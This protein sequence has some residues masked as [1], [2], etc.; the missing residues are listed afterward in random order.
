M[1]LDSQLPIA[2]S[3]KAR[4]GI[5][6]VLQYAEQLAMDNGLLKETD[7]YSILAEPQFREFFGKYTVQVGSTGN[8]GLSIGI[9][10]AKLGFRVMVHMSMD[11][12]QWKKDLLRE[13]GVTVVEYPDDYGKAVEEGRKRSQS[14]PMSYF[15]DDENSISLFLGYTVAGRRL[16]RQ[17]EQRGI[18]VDAEHP[19]FVYLPCGIGGAPGG[20]AFG[21]KHEFGDNVHCFF[22]EPT[23]ACCMLLGMATGRHDGI[24]V[25][26]VGLSGKT[27]ADGLA[28]GRPSAFV[29]RTVEPFLSGVVTVKDE[30]LFRW[31]KQLLDAEGIFIEP[32]S[33]AAFAP[34]LFKDKMEE[35]IRRE[36]LTSVMENACHLG[37]ATGGR[38]VPQE[39]RE[40][41]I[42]MGTEK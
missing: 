12:K 16:R 20:V 15:V 28:V 41:Y 10:S 2:G 4:G 23:E 40:K 27:Q 33:C 30:R 32:S 17:A 25:Q 42:A 5:Y 14:D 37:W 18:Q 39:E 11:A 22:T 1:K 31:M 21:L 9:M 36:G 8:L 7:D 29:G 6:E 3:I 19:L 26:D 13:K 38:L 34:V 24:S 35:Y